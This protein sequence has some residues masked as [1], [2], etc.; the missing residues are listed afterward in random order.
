[1][2][3]NNELFSVGPKKRVYF[4]KGNLQYQVSTGLWRFAERQ[5]DYLGVE[6]EGLSSDYDGWMDLFGWGTGSNPMLSGDFEDYKAFT[7][8]GGNPI[9][10]GGNKAGLWRTLKIDEW[11]Y[12]LYERRTKSGISFAKATLNDIKGLIL[13]PDNWKGSSFEFCNANDKGSDFEDNIISEAQWE[14]LEKEGLV[15]LPVVEPASEYWSSTGLIEYG[16]CLVISGDIYE[17][18]L[19][20]FIGSS[21]RLVMD[22]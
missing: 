20:P 19:E 3:T 17:E 5:Y 13:V 14:T 16:W 11:G 4:S 22:K 21:V 7:D 1:M 8:W 6:S 10:N 9:I 2:N 12:L 15:F 18:D